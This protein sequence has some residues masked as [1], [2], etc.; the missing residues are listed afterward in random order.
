MIIVEGCDNTGKSTVLAKLADGL[1]LMIV[2]NRKRP[3]GTSDI[4]FFNTRM[5]ELSKH[6]PLILDRHPVISEPVYGPICRGTS[7]PERYYQENV[8]R[9]LERIK[10]LVVYCRPKNSTILNFGERDQMEGVVK[11]GLKLIQAYDSHIKFINQFLE[12]VTYDYETHDYLGLQRLVETHL[13]GP[14]H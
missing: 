10:A 11:N 6:F 5:V 4:S 1:K 9:E 7:W 2:N 14:I 8:L 12:V 3:S 13:K